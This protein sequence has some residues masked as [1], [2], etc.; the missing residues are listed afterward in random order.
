MNANRQAIETAWNNLLE[1][2]ATAAELAR[3]KPSGQPDSLKE[4]AAKLDTLH[5]AVRGLGNAWSGI[6]DL[7]PAEPIESA[8][9]SDEPG[10]LPES[11]YWKP[12]AKTLL[13]LGGKAQAGD[14][15]AAV[16]KAMDST[17]QPAD[18]Q[19]LRAGAVRWINRT[20][21]ARERLKQHG[22]IRRN[23]PH[24]HWELTEVGERW[25]QSDMRKLPQPVEEPDPRQPPLPF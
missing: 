7:L 15:I 6:R 14:A 23:M 13:A 9:L 25:A 21:F 10:A 5:A 2:I 18:R 17:L 16:G 3:S 1:A 22:L 4:V 12:L 8:D 20:Q 19:L 24:G 11:A